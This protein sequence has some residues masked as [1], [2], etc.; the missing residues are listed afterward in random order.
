MFIH[1]TESGWKEA[2][3]IVCHGHHQDL[4]KLDPEVVIPA[5]Q[6]V[7]YQTSSKEISDLYQQVYVLKR[8]P[9][10]PPCGPERAWQ[11]TKEIMSPLKD[12]LRW[13]EVEQTGG[14]GE[15]E[16]ASTHPP[17]PC[18]QASQRGRWDTSEE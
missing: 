2:K 6:L 17:C 10:P 3:R 4:P 5:V 14:G 1:E 7:G 8:L 13:K 15:L 11:I 12:H 16:S 18:D 9:G